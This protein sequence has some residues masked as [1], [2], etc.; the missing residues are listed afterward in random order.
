MAASPFADGRKT[1]E[2]KYPKATFILQSGETTARIPM[3]QGQSRIP[4]RADRPATSA[5]LETEVAA[6]P[7]HAAS[8]KEGW[9]AS[10]F[11]SRKTPCGGT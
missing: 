5:G 2:P 10:R 8:R 11:R 1:D 6:G 3:E 9:R 7:V 4:F